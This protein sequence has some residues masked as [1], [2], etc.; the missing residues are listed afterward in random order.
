[1]K[2]ASA[3]C[4]AW[5]LAKRMPADETWEV[6]WELQEQSSGGV[7]LRNVNGQLNILYLL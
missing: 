7:S 3:S 5:I 2:I 4:A 6:D 1:M